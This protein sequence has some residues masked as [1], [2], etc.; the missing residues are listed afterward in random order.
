MENTPRNI[1]L[2]VGSLIA[3]YV[4]ASFFLTL[5][6]GLININYPDP[7]ESYWQI[8]SA[9]DNIRLGVAMLIVFFPTYIVLT[10]YMNRFR[11]AEQGA[12]YQTITKWLIYLSLLIGG[13]VLLGT[14]V[15][16]IYTF[17]NG[18]M[19]TRFLLKAAAVVG[20]VGAA[21]HYYLLDARGV[22]IKEEGKSIM[23]G[24]GAALM[25][26]LAVAYGLANIETPSVVRE[27]KLDEKQVSDL[28]NIQWQIDAYMTMSSSTLPESIEQA[29]AYNGSISPSAPESREAYSYER[30]DKGFKLCAT[31]SRDSVPSDFASPSFT[32]PAARIKNPD[33]WNYK[34]GRYCFDRVTKS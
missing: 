7:S 2:Q 27:M 29:F 8:E 23:F 21:F 15:T 20:V 34:A 11:R 33:S 6:F 14:L 13:L 30:T 26:F 19:T 3:L 32:D 28:Q 17:L 22:W 1:V 16:T 4:S 5:I 31:F 25:V 12:L 24:V 10:R 18:E 9:T